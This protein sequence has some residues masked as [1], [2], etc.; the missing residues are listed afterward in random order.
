MANKLHGLSPA[1]G[2]TRTLSAELIDRAGSPVASERITLTD[3][4]APEAESARQLTLHPASLTEWDIE[5]PALYTLRL[6]LDD[7][8]SVSAEDIVTGF[9]RAEFDPDR[10]FLLNG[11]SVKLKG[12]NMHRTMPVL[13][14]EYPMLLMSIASRN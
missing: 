14:P 2:E 1:P 4:P 3:L 10:G 7:G 11:R 12:V 5:N 6:R 9:R 13:E 8:R